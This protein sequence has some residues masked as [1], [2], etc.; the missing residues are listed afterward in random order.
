LYGETWSGIERGR[1]DCE[2]EGT[3]RSFVF[4]LVLGLGFFTREIFFLLH[5]VIAIEWLFV[6]FLWD[7]FFFLLFFFGEFFV[8]TRCGEDYGGPLLVDDILGFLR[9]HGFV[10]PLFLLIEMRWCGIS[11]YYYLRLYFF[12]CACFLFFFAFAFAFMC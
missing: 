8:L 9:H 10:M 3:E 2:A 4:R 12:L 11:L 1:G 6:F 5:E 7:P